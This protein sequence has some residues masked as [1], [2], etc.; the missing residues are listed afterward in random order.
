MQGG[1]NHEAAHQ[2]RTNNADDDSE[3]D[4]IS[5]DLNGS[6]NRSSK[7]SRE[8]S[9]TNRRSSSFYVEE[10]LDGNNNKI[11][12]KE[13]NVIEKRKNVS[14][15]RLFSL[16]KPEFPVLA[17]GSVAACV[18]G[19][20]FPFLGLLLSKAIKIFFEPPT[21]LKKDSVFWALM[22][23]ALGCVT[24]VAIPVKSLFFGIAGGKLVERIRALTFEKIVHQEISW[25]DDPANSR[26]IFFFVLFQNFKY[27]YIPISPDFYYRNSKL[28]SSYE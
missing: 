10:K 22:C 6:I 18:Q 16:N 7:I 28:S 14:I 9:S 5:L 8:L 3:D 13:S 21:Q 25:F 4:M 19:V 11:I 26:F 15:L 12:E 27:I 24:V 17:L 20:I 1:N 23:V 2:D